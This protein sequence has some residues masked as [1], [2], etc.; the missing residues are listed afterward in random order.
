MRSNKIEKYKKTLKLTNL[1]KE[2]LVGLMLG[3][4]HLEK[5]KNKA[6]LKIEYSLKAKEYV[7]WLYQIFQKWTLS[8][9]KIKIQQNSKKYL[10][11]TVIHEKLGRY[12]SLFYHKRK[13]IIP[14][15]INDL[16]TNRSLAIWFMDDGSRKS[17]ECKG[18]VINTQCFSKSDINKLQKILRNKFDLKTSLKVERKQYCIYIPSSEIDKFRKLIGKYILNSMKYKLY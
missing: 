1:Q 12:H 5:R 4:G 15:N 3:D 9:P 11:S 10:F 14:K 13:K 8:S 18:K 17:K 2:I 7:E 6:R 16:I